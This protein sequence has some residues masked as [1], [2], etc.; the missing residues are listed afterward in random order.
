[1]CMWYSDLEIL[2]GMELTEHTHDGHGPGVGG[3]EHLSGHAHGT[4]QGD[5]VHTCMM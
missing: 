4:L 2:H 3:T 5:V 1:M